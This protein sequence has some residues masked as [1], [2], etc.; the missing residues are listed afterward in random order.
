MSKAEST[1]EIHHAVVD[2]PAGGREW[3]T[4]VIDYRVGPPVNYAFF[5]TPRS[6]KL[7]LWGEHMEERWLKE[8]SSACHELEQEN[9][10]RAMYEAA[11][12]ADRMEGEF[13]RAERTEVPA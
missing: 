11:R 10:D 12:E 6:Q 2:V 1:D 4:Q 5:R 13:L 9:S 3:A 8:L 7:V